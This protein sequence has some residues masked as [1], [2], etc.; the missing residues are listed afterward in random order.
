M[1]S[2]K[3][4]NVVDKPNLTPY[5]TNVGAP[6]IQAYQLAFNELVKLNEI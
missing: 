1:E 3:V 5:P 6:H 2:K 4:D